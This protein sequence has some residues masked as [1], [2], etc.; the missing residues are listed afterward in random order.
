M[1]CSQ[2]LKLVWTTTYLYHKFNKHHHKGKK[3]VQNCCRAT[4]LIL[5]ATSATSQQWTVGE[6]AAGACL[7]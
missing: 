7:L 3:A 5:W 4:A 1:D 6:K 2:T